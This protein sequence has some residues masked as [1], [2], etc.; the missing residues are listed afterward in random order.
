[1]NLDKEGKAIQTKSFKQIW[2]E[3]MD[4]HK[5]THTNKT[6]VD[7]GL[8]TSHQKT[9]KT[10]HRSKCKMPKWD[11]PGGPVAKT[12]CSQM[13]RAQIQLLVREQDSTCQ[14]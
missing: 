12:S 13:Q 7:T 2:M 10:Y 8:N 14:N 11:F 3:I 1:M 5:N 6:N 9:L 4:I